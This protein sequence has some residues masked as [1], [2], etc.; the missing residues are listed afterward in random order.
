MYLAI[1]KKKKKKRKKKDVVFGDKWGPK[2][3]SEDSH[4]VWSLYSDL[5]NDREKVEP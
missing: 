1:K 3:K 2:I 4:E 5:E